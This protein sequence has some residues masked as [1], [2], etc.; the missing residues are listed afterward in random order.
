MYLFFP[1]FRVK[2]QL[3]NA[4]KK[5]NQHV[6]LV[7]CLQF[8]SSYCQ[9][10]YGTYIFSKNTIKENVQFL[11]YTKQIRKYLLISIFSSCQLVREWSYQYVY[12]YIYRT[13]A[14]ANCSRIITAPHKK[15]AIFCF[16]F[17]FCAKV[18]SQK[19]EKRIVTAVCHGART[20][21]NLFTKCKIYPN[22][23]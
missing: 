6:F 22:L 4:L 16:L 19:E 14:M 18:S 13:R 8:K 9:R 17:H 11:I 3:N 5:K 2:L 23:S 21:G 15:H 12:I 1:L 10:A 7:G 20:V